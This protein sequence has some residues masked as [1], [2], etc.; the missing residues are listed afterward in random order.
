MKWITDISFNNKLK[1]KLQHLPLFQN[2]GLG[3]YSE[4]GYKSW[5]QGE[6][7]WE[8]GVSVIFMLGNGSCLIQLLNG[9]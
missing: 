4:L 3:Q 6:G 2:E 1:H 9:R 7:N 8:V 5:N